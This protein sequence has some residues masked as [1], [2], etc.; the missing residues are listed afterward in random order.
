MTFESYFPEQRHLLRQ[1]LIRRARLLPEDVDGTLEVGVGSRVSL[2]D[3]IARGPDTV[4]YVVL[5]AAR[6]FGVK[7]PDALAKLIICEVG[8]VVE[9]GA[10]LAGRS[11]RRGRRLFAPITGRVRYI[12][13]GRIV[14]QEVAEN[15]ELEAG[16]SGQVVEVIPG[17][18]AVIE[19]QGAVLQGVWGNDR[20]TIGT[21]QMEPEAGLEQIF[22]NLIDTQYQ[23]AIVVT[24][25]PLRAVSLRVIEDQGINGV[26]APSMEP[27]LL[28]EALALPAALLL[29]EGFGTQ[30]LSANVLSFLNEM[31]GRQATIDAVRPGPLETRRP[32]VV[33][34]VPIEKRSSPPNL[35]ARLAVGTEVRLMRGSRAGLSGRVVEVPKLPVILENGLRVRCARVELV[36]G[37]TV[38]VPVANIAVSGQ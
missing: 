31:A 7:A 13:E 25:Q 4:P 11:A 15:V 24:R 35:Q 2:R 27:E 17:R 32:E 20:R 6:F 36:T 30:R 3:L 28:S 5:D 10:V 9:A 8:E 33:I 23:S 29:I 19:T 12:G 1:T 14:L 38:T 37:E 21:L 34:N 16:V 26:I 22:T 18:G